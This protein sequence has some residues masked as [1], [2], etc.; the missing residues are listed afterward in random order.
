M[1]NRSNSCLNCFQEWLFVCEDPILLEVSLILL[2]EDLC[3]L[4]N[5][6]KGENTIKVE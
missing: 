4:L 5:Q 6:G 2:K 3:E 1:S